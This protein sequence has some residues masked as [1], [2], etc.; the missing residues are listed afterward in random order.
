MRPGRPRA[1]IDGA[2]A[3]MVMIVVRVAPVML[4]GVIMIVDMRMRGAVR[5]RMLMPMMVMV[6][7]MAMGVAMAMLMRV[8]GTRRLDARLARAKPEGDARVKIGT[9]KKPVLEHASAHG[10]AH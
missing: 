4:M 9:P 5:M 2:F 1:I 7:A 10:G 6:M 3:V 8:L